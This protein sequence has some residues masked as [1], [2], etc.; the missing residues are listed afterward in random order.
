MVGCALQP[1]HRRLL[2][3]A[4]L[5]AQPTAVVGQSL[6]EV[7]KQDKERRKKLRVLAAQRSDPAKGV[8][9]GG[10]GLRG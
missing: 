5:I 6:A 10:F 8:A 9:P 7:A 4:V 1:E 2:A 3:C